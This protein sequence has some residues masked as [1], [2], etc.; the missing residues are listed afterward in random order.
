MNDVLLIFSFEWN[1]VS[2]YV[3]LRGGFGDRL[4]YFLIPAIMRNIKSS[5]FLGVSLPSPCTDCRTAVIFGL[6][7][8]AFF[9]Q[10]ASVRISGP[11]S[12]C[13]S[14]LCVSATAARHQVS[15]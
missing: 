7:M 8:L 5:E 9:I 3:L 1:S 6:F 12:A 11:V 2:L 13:G 4:P 10:L 14:D 15:P